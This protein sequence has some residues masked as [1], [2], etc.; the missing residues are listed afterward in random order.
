[1][2]QKRQICDVMSNH[3]I[4]YFMFITL[5]YV[6]LCFI[7]SNHKHLQMRQTLEATFWL[8]GCGA[9]SWRT[10]VATGRDWT[11]SFYRLRKLYFYAF[12]TCCFPEFLVLNQVI[13]VMYSDIYMGSGRFPGPMELLLQQ[14]VRV[15]K[16]RWRWFHLNK[17]MLLQPLIKKLEVL[18]MI[19]QWATYCINDNNDERWMVVL[20][21]FYLT[22]CKN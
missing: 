6:M 20:I 11:T 5:Y 22:S 17:S 19:N 13:C 15:S 16:T 8:Q 10:A 14:L 9:L 4:T 2:Y 21:D 1:M 12:E 7:E 18:V 3:I